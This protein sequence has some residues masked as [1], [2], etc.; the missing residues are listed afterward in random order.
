VD[1]P[2]SVPSAG[3]VNGKFVD[4]NPVG[5][6]P[7]SLIPAQWGNA[8]TTEILGVI[9]GAGFIPDE[10]DNTQLADAIRKIVTDNN[11][12]AATE[13]AA[14][15]LMLATAA[16]VA[17]GVDDTA[18]VTSKKLA[19]KLVQATEVAF[20]WL[21]IATQALTNT[22]SDDVAAVT[23]KKL[24]TAVQG[25]ALTAFTTAGTAPAFTL[26][27]VPAITA[28]A[29]NQRFQVTFNAAGGATPTLNVS[30]LGAKNLKQ[31]TSTGV[32]IA[33]IIAASQ[34]SDVVYDGTD[35][36]VLDQL[37]NSVGA[38]PAQF[39]GS[40]NLATTAFVQGVGL[41]FSNVTLASASMTLT[42][43]TH[44]GAIVVGNSSSAINV[45][46]PAV[47]TVPAKVAIKFWN[48]AVGTMTLLASG[49]D[50]IY[51]PGT[52]TS[53]SVP[54]GS[55]VT[56]VSSGVGVWYAVD[57]PGVGVGQTRQ[58]FT[59]GTTRVA[60]TT[61]YNTTGRPIW[62]YVENNGSNTIGSN[63]SLTVG[64]RAMNFPWAWYTTPTASAGGISTMV[65]PGESYVAS[66][67]SL[68]IEIR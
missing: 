63:G 13:A 43:A 47:S 17:A 2:K 26:T 5:G 37:P 20:G 14:G 33:A 21:K 62:I 32:K 51:L 38:T 31:Y 7:G 54:T 61:Y 25:Q 10:A 68:W 3:L 24:A 40:T 66:G 53:F 36:V 52:A 41:Q 35:F 22:G 46:L 64:G 50:S 59:V 57:M 6:S 28:Y 39:D 34:T 42:A 30:G 27:T 15:V 23:P 29:A 55:W 65:L 18:S 16:Q 12:G 4:E 8:V 60:G 9:Q 45:T 11:P 49:S 1:Y 19:Q 67:A 58:I 44:A 48:Y 56:L